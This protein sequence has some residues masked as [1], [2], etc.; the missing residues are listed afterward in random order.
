MLASSIIVMKRSLENIGTSTIRRKERNELYT[1][2]SDYIS[3]P[4]FAGQEWD[5]SV[6]GHSL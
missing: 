2:V 6:Q 4:S 1:V 3:A 5:L